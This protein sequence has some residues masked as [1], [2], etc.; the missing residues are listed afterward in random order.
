VAPSL[1]ER[2]RAK[3]R[4]GARVGAAGEERGARGGVTLARGAV[5]WR[6]VAVRE[7]ASVR[8]VVEEEGDGLGVARLCGGVQRGRAVVVARVDVGGVAPQQ[9]GQF[10]GPTVL[11]SLLQPRRQQQPPRAPRKRPPLLPLRGRGGRDGEV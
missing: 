3:P 2:R 9:C 7:R 4:R 1:V 8:S 6:V 5:E 11:R 10:L